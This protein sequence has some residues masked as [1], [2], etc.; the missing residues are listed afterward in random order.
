M[1]SVVPTPGVREGPPS[2]FR[3]I[4]LRT[5]NRIFV[6]VVALCLAAMF[7]GTYFTFVGLPP[8]PDKIATTDGEVLFAYEDITAGKAVFHKYNLMSYGTLLGNG[9]YYGPD[10]TAE[11]LGLVSAELAGR[12]RA[13]LELV[14]SS[15]VIQ[16]TLTLPSWWRGVHHRAREHYHDFYVLGNLEAGVGP[17]TIATAEEAHKF[18]DFIAWASWICLARRPGSDG[19]YTNNWPYEPA[20]GNTPTPTNLFWTAMTIGIVLVLAVLIVLA[21][22][23]VEVEPVPELPAAIPARFNPSEAQRALLPLFVV[24]TG[25]FLAQVLAG[26]FIAN[27]FASRL[28]F[29]GL[30]GLLGVERATVLPFS[31]VRAAHVDLGV[32]WVLG[33]WMAA[34]LFLAPFLGGRERSWLKSVTRLM[35]AMLVIGI[36]GTVA[37]IYLAVRNLL[38]DTWFWLGTE[39]ME[40]VDMGRVWKLVI[41]L[42]FALWVAAL[43]GWYGRVMR[44]PS[45]HIPRILVGMGIAIS[46]AF[47][48]SLAFLPSTHFVLA[49]F[50]RWWTIHLW[51]EGIFAFFQVAVTAVVF[52]N[53]GLVGRRLA[54]KA[55]YL[56]GFLVVIAG[57][58]AVGHHYW[59][60]GEP[61]FWISIGSIFSTLEVVPLLLL[62]FHALATYR[63]IGAHAQARAHRVALWFIIAG[64]VWQFIGSGVL[65]LLINF[66]I[67]NY[68]EHGTY[69]TVAHAHGAMLGGFG[70][71]AIGLMLYG[72]RFLVPENLWPER[73][74]LWAYHLLNAGLALMLLLSV[75]PVGL[76]QLN[77]AFSSTYDT[78]RSLAFY[79]RPAIRLLMKL[80][81]PGDT[82]IILGAALLTLQVVRIWWISERM[83]RFGT[84]RIPMPGPGRP[85]ANV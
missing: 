15:Q 74:L 11:Y 9:A 81:M 27:A 73:P 72:F 79:D 29:Y 1:T 82:L 8:V 34:A 59:W 84:S 51:V 48:P 47:L 5:L 17:G 54:T 13:D 65:G 21:Y 83:K 46:V 16:G 76:I 58:L 12:D 18:A 24:A 41:M 40:Y 2:S 75:I 37:G 42:G 23:Y 53:L 71:L 19:S 52:L 25:L 67:V 50:W 3:P 33:M 7:A 69:L 39:G 6:A 31:A 22:E 70:F 77:E 78:A 63:D 38:G 85:P 64:A 62:L 36:V 43:V 80:R 55:V 26:A 35:T 49:D 45:G 68:Y 44:S 14:R 10:Y 61:S 66:P 28:D 30:F 4:S 57:T 56:E 60:V 32:F 20:L